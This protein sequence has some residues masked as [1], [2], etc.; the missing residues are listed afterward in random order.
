MKS[1]TGTPHT[2][3]TAADVACQGLS[4]APQTAAGPIGH[5]NEL[6][7]DDI[8]RS[9]K[10]ADPPDDNEQA[11]NPRVVPTGTTESKPGNAEEDSAAAQLLLGIGSLSG[12][13][14]GEEQRNDGDIKQNEEGA[15]A[16][17]QAPNRRPRRRCAANINVL[18]AAEL[19]SE[20]DLLPEETLTRSKPATR[21]N[22]AEPKQNS[23]SE[24]PG[25]DEE[26]PPRDGGDNDNDNDDD[27]DDF[28]RRFTPAREAA[29]PSREGSEQPDRCPSTGYEPGALLSD[30]GPPSESGPVAA[31]TDEQEHVSPAMPPFG[32]SL[33]NAA[34]LQ[35]GLSIPLM[36][37]MFPSTSASSKS[38]LTN[39]CEKFLSAFGHLHP[40]GSASLL[41]LNDVAETLGVP[42]RRLYDVINVFESIDIM[43]RIG[44]LQYEFC[45]YD[46]LPQL[47]QQLANDEIAGLPVEDR[48][49]RAPANGRNSLGSQQSKR[50]K[51]VADAAPGAPD[52]VP[53]EEDPGVIVHPGPPPPRTTSHSLYVLS[54][55]LVR[56]LLTTTGA[57]SLANAAAILVG[58]GGVT[59][60]MESRSQSQITVERRLYDI[61]SI[62]CSLGLVE[63][64]YLKKRQPAFEWIYGWRPGDT[65][66]PPELAVATIARQPPPPMHTV[67]AHRHA[68]EAV[69]GRRKKNAAAV[70]G[71]GKSNKK[72]R[73]GGGPK[74]GGASMSMS[75]SMMHPASL[76]MAGFPGMMPTIPGMM[77]SPAS[78]M[79]ASPA[80]MQGHA[81]PM[82]MSP[83]ALSSMAPAAA[84]MSPADAEKMMQWQS[85]FNPVVMG[86]MLGQG[87][88]PDMSG[89]SLQQMQQMSVPM[90]LQMQMLSAGGQPV[91]PS[92]PQT[93]D[94]AVAASREQAFV[95][96]SG[97]MPPSALLSPGGLPSEFLATTRQQQQQ[98]QQPQQPRGP[99]GSHR[100]MMQQ[101]RAPAAGFEAPT[102]MWNERQM[103]H[104]QQQQP[105]QPPS[106]L[107]QGMTM[108]D[109][110]A[111]QVPSGLPQ[112]HY[113]Q[114]PAGQGSMGRGGSVPPMQFSMG[115]MSM[116]A[117]IPGMMQPEGMQ[118]LG[119]IPGSLPH[120][121]QRTGHA[122]GNGGL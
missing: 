59:D 9:L 72:Q 27:A 40:D 18:V 97:L 53:Q 35:H 87:A 121:D 56:M 100:G 4:V 10:P 41:M 36:P 122:P 13:E 50:A 3:P 8:A 6:L 66:A 119:V 96:A 94:G 80:E 28:P 34:M 5:A 22:T 37:T 104:F 93:R 58:P 92:H 25:Q 23:S 120:H 7:L 14:D 64:V 45:G 102:A 88:V 115:Q 79:F 69:G 43:R 84:S 91:Q 113:M 52:Q 63:R 75:A 65:H 116:M 77:P 89:F 83:S 39:L 19:A 74:G 51:A 81:I 30:A 57:I 31:P 108:Q 55:R 101:Q 76:V 46:H 29:A 106:E 32:L 60:P 112:Q 98:Q 68:M 38:E 48:I 12:S 67:I 99:V 47:L 103:M 2:E 20:D 33:P 105:Q 42:R 85:F 54:R 117:G 15:H 78:W 11:T 44:K 95:S 107:P 17:P 62:L 49:R 26:Q 110:L 24:F 73:V 16:E 21:R 86:G 114:P 70:T 71:G 118:G 109:M 1:D 61:G 82:S 90:Q 111:F